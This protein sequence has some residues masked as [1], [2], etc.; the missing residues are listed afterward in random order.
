MPGPLYWGWVKGDI[1]QLGRA[2]LGLLAKAALASALDGGGDV[3]FFADYRT[4]AA[5]TL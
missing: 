2:T 1:Y 4:L 5:I 3:V